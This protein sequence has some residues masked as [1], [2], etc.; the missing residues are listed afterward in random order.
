VVDRFASVTLDETQQN[1]AVTVSDIKDVIVIHGDGSQQ[2]LGV[3]G[4]LDIGIHDTMKDLFVNLIGAVVFS[5]IGYFY[6]KRRGKGSF[7]SNFIP[8][9]QMTDDAQA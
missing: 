7:A 8:K 2:A 9:V 3:G 4:Y 1:N 6:V 5:I